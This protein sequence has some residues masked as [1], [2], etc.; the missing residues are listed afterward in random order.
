MRPAAV[1]G[2]A[3]VIG[4]TLVITV[5]DPGLNLKSFT[6]GL[7]A[8]CAALRSRE[9]LHVRPWILFWFFLSTYTRLCCRTHCFSHGQILQHVSKERTPGCGGFGW[10]SRASRGRTAFLKR[11]IGRKWFWCFSGFLL[12]TKFTPL[13]ILGQNISANYFVFLIF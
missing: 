7:L 5:V 2:G 11:D 8:T 4:T 6:K 10:D 13:H 3:S 12:W 1:R 9:L